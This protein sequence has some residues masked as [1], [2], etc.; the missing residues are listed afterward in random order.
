MKKI[1]TLMAI[2]AM[3][4]TIMVSC[5]GSGSK[6]APFGSLPEKCEKFKQESDKLGEAMQNV[7]SEAEKAELMKK[8]EELVKTWKPKIE[9]S[10]KAL[11]GKTV[12][13]A[14][15]AFEITE[16]LSF[17]FN[18]FFSEDKLIP[19]LKVNGGANIIADRDSESKYRS[20]EAVYLVGY[21]AEGKEVYSFNVG[22]IAL[23]K[24]DEKSF[25]AAGTPVD[26][27][28]FQFGLST[29]DCKDVQT[30]KLEVR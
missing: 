28:T 30:L 4:A 20:T 1:V 3:A 9:E 5:S 29:Q 17:Q 21:N 25:V 6:G 19:S 22:T 12:E 13:I 27:S 14:E 26:F 10:A 16:P 23:Q 24:T 18:G 15:C 11:E 8:H 2:V 7:K